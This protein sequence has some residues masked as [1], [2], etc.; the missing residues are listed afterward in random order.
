MLDAETGLVRLHNMPMHQ[1]HGIVASMFDFR[2][3]LIVILMPVKIF[4]IGFVVLKLIKADLLN[5]F[6]HS[7][8]MLMLIAVTLI[9]LENFMCT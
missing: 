1:A 4:T 3:V 9:T 8:S 5:F 2:K 7:S 6:V